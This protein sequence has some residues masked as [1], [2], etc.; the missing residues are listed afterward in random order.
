MVVTGGPGDGCDWRR[1]SGDWKT[2]GGDWRR[3]VQ[4]WA[5]WPSGETVVVGG[6][7]RLAVD[8]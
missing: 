2:D 3:D 6:S 1:D 7:S 5:P 4:W 8:L